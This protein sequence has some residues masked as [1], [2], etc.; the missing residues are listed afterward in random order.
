MEG[1]EIL[2]QRIVVA[3]DLLEQIKSVD[4]MINLHQQKQDEEDLM[5]IQY[6][7][8]RTQLLKELKAILEDLN[9]KPTDLA[10]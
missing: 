1:L 8:K 4:E 3:A 6:Q 2:D 5:L 7:Y 9:I 10:A